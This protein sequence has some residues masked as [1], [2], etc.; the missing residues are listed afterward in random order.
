MV[1][2]AG[3]LPLLHSRD[4][5]FFR[6]FEFSLFRRALDLRPQADRLRKWLTAPVGDQLIE[7]KRTFALKVL[8]RL[9][10]PLSDETLD[11]AFKTGDADAVLTA[12]AYLARTPAEEQ[13][14]GRY[15]DALV[16][17]LLETKDVETWS[18]PFADLAIA[19]LGHGER[20]GGVLPGE[21]LIPK[22]R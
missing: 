11:L 1:G 7:R 20:F 15:Q 21:T 16:K 19:W 12:V 5:R 6:E 3:R 18:A 13:R 14:V 4:R 8:M 10:E 2:D 22:R 17:F 9:G